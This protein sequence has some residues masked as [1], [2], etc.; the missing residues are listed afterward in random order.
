MV[1]KDMLFLMDNKEMIDKEYEGRH[2]AVSN[3]KIVAVGGSVHE[4]YQALKEM[5]IDDPLVLYVPMEGEE[6]LLI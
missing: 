1:S 5:D 6:A 4:V 2:I 3:G